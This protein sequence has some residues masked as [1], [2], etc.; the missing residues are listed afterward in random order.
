MLDGQATC[1]TGKAMLDGQ[2]T[3][4]D[5]LATHEAAGPA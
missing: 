4:L 1:W 2:A 5:G 3:L